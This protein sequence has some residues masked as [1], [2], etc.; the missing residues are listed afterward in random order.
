VDMDYRVRRAHAHDTVSD[1]AG[2]E[3]QLLCDCQHG[4]K[5]DGHAQVK[6]CTATF[7]S[8]PEVYNMIVHVQEL[9]QSLLPPLT[10]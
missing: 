4:T 9:W 1:H 6:P 7:T 5:A 2:P 3:L 10:R 8:V